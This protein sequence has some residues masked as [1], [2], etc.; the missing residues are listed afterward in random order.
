MG[1]CNKL[2]RNVHKINAVMNND[3]DPPKKNESHLSVLIE[4]L[5]SSTSVTCFIEDDNFVYLYIYI[6]VK[7]NCQ[8]GT[9]CV[10]YL[11]MSE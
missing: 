11:L 3:N 5:L 7:L 2:V 4:K 9:K 1:G 10:I 8:F 6:T